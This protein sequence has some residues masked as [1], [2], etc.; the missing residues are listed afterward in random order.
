[1]FPVPMLSKS[2]NGR[3]VRTVKLKKAIN[4]YSRRSSWLV[5]N[6]VSN[7]MMNTLV[8]SAGLETPS[9]R[10]QYSLNGACPIPPTSFTH[11]AFNP[12][13]PLAAPS[14]DASKVL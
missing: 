3:E 2:V 12:N 14:K 5:A 9:W 8:S 10:A 4:Y 13:L 11:G 6:V 1:M 7:A